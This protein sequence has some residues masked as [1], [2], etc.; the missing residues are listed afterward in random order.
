MRG[1]GRETADSGSGDLR[2]RVL[3]LA[4]P[5]YARRVR[6]F[7]KTGPGAYAENDM[8]A[9][10]RVPALRAVARAAGEPSLARILRLL[11]D[12]VHEVRMLALLLLIRRFEAGDAA[13]R[14]RVA[15]FY[16]A[17]TRHINN[18]DLVDVSAAPIVGAWLW[19]RDTASLD[20]L[21]RSPQMWERRIAIVATHAFIRRGRFD[22]TLR[23]A[24][25]L[26][27]DREDLLHKAAGWMLRE[28][29]K[30]D[31]RALDRFLARHRG[32][33]PRTMLRYALEHRARR[34]LT[35][36]RTRGPGARSGCADG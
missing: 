25:A 1:T 8:F 23:I 9:G 36:A 18:W 3:R 11:R 15:D 33:M 13:C 32:V 22:E 19:G 26:L 27:G 16:L 29:D 12:P 35:P 4:D 34:P 31:P 20:A 24:E 7:F 2:G 21:A 14:R 6:F 5:A 28:V 10:V 17:N 30:R